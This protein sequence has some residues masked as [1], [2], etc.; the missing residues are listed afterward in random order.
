MRVHGCTLF[1]LALALLAG[2]QSKVLAQGNDTTATAVGQKAAAGGDE[3]PKALESDGWEVHP[4]GFKALD[5]LPF[6]Y[7]TPG[8]GYWIEIARNPG[9]TTLPFPNQGKEGIAAA[10]EKNSLVVDTNGDGKPD[11]AL[12]SDID[13]LPVQLVLADGQK[14][15]Y[16][17]RAEKSREGGYKI[18]RNCLA[19]ATVGKTKVTFIDDNSN[20]IWND[21]GQ[22]AVAVGNDHYAAPLSSV[23]NIDGKLFSCKVDKAGTKF[24]TKAYEQASGT[25]N[26][27]KGFK[28][29]G[30]LAW[31]VMGNGGVFFDVAGAK[32][33]MLVPVGTYTMT[34][35][36]CRKGKM[37]CRIRQGGMEAV[38]I[39]DGGTAAPDWGMDVY[40]DFSYELKNKQVL[41]HSSDVKVVGKAK[42]EYHSFKPAAITPTVEVKDMS[43]TGKPGKGN[44]GTMCLS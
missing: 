33:G 26:M 16:E 12:K 23:I 6:P 28:A 32:D 44:K 24:W 11:M 42:E 2:I 21:Y 19:T 18:Q 39:A 9:D 43:T 17:I 27:Q 40:L 1:L 8:E 41:V 37:S 25:L 29:N 36:E 7:A 22:D 3:D 10:F 38:T 20:G 30:Q 15:T 14:T 34:T 4:L 13:T 5:K 35:G 31:C